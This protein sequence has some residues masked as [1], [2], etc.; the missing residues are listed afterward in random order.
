MS[1][2]FSVSVHVYV[3]MFLLC[4]FVFF[5]FLFVCVFFFYFVDLCGLIQIK[6]ERKERKNLPRHN[7]LSLTSLI[8]KILTL[9]DSLFESSMKQAILLIIPRP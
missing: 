5:F 6:K 8:I 4:V 3:S 1:V 7:Y 2:Y 9:G